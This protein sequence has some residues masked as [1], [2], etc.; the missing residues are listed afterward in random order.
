MALLATVALGLTGLGGTAMSEASSSPPGCVSFKEFKS[1]KRGMTRLQVNR[2]TDARA[3]G[4][5]DTGEPFS[6]LIYDACDD[7]HAV[8]VEYR[9]RASGRDHVI[10]KEWRLSEGLPG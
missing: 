8:V 10:G 4:A 3:V 6:A 2:M 9:Q 7:T 5:L 1:I